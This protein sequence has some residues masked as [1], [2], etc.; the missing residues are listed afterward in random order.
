MKMKTRTSL[1]HYFQV[2]LGGALICAAT[3]AACTRAAGN[4]PLVTPGEGR[5]AI[6]PVAGVTAARAGSRGDLSPGPVTGTAF[7]ANTGK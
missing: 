7:P 3:L 1:M 5:A 2:S 4:L 6:V